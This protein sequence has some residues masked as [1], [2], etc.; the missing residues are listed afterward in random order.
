MG[1]IIHMSEDHDKKSMFTKEEW[2]IKPGE[3][4]GLT[5]LIESNPITDKDDEALK[6]IEE[7]CV[8]LKEYT[9]RMAREEKEKNKFNQ[10]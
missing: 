8:K 9:D 1:K 7:F 5:D 2:D 4:K 3:F 10:H 6:E